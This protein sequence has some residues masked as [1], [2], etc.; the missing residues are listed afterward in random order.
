MR[1][2]INWQTLAQI[3]WDSRSIVCF[4]TLHFHHFGPPPTD[5]NLKPIRHK[6]SSFQSCKASLLWRGDA[7]AALCAA[8]ALEFQV[9]NHL[10]LMSVFFFRTRTDYGVAGY[11]E[12]EETENLMALILTEGFRTNADALAGVERLAV[13]IPDSAFLEKPADEPMH[14]PGQRQDLSSEL[15]KWQSHCQLYRWAHSDMVL[16]LCQRLE[17]KLRSALLPGRHSCVGHPLGW[18]DKDFQGRI[19]DP[20]SYW[21]WFWVAGFNDGSLCHSW[22]LRQCPW[23]GLDK[24]RWGGCLIL[25]HVCLAKLRNHNGEHE[26]TSC[27]QCV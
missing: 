5:C 4:L 18:V 23:C 10:R 3:W 24:Q 21:W 19:V 2:P 16:G 20:K 6:S 26:D 13:M 15:F 9:W 8:L 27:P 1:G 7:R 11:A 17:E 22:C 12:P 14:F 25:D